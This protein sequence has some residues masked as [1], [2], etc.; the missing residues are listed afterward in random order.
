L[1]LGRREAPPEGVVVDP[2]TAATIRIRYD[3]GQ[4]HSTKSPA[5]QAAQAPAPGGEID[6]L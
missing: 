4:K 1:S 5:A 3:S 6:G 2:A